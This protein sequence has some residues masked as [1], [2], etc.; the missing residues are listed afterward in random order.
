MS[1]LSISP[2]LY[3]RAMAGNKDAQFELAE[4]YMQSENDEHVELAEEW[5]LKAAQ[6]GHVEAM[7]WL[8]EGYAVYAKDM[9]EEDPEESKAYFEHAHRWLEQAAKH[10]H[11]AAILEL[12]NFFR[13][14]DVVEKDVT[15]SIELVEQSAKLGEVQAMRDLAFIYANGLGIDAD[16]DKADYWTEKANTLEQ[17][18]A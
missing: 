14:G 8:G 4:I 16:E 1:E 3:N 11:P 15:K 2:A 9:Q 10:N 13:R 7:Y 5:A 18:E 6:L 12:A 17:P